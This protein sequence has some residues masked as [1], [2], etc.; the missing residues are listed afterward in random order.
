MMSEYKKA[1]L[2]LMKESKGY[3]SLTLT[4]FSKAFREDIMKTILENKDYNLEKT[5]VLLWTPMFLEELS[6]LNRVPTG[7]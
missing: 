7:L 5:P 2:K 3:V 4:E 1:V 6:L